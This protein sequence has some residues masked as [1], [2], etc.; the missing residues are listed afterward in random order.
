MG[1][2]LR[3]PQSKSSAALATINLAIV[4]GKYG[5]SDPQV[6][7]QIHQSYFLKGFQVFNHI[8]PQDLERLNSYA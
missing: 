1:K 6:L 8:Y 4:N 7:P 5:L 2:S 3:F